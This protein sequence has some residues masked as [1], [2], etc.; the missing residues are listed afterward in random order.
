MTAVADAQ[1]PATIGDYLLRAADFLH[2]LAGWRRAGVAFVAGSVS[3]LSFAPFAIFPL[4]LLSIATL[5]LLLDGSLRTKRPHV[6]AAWI[7]WCFASGQFLFGLYWVGYAFL[8]D[9]AD[10]AWQIPLVEFFLPGGLALFIAAATFAASFYWRPGA[11]RIFVLTLS[12]ACAEWL[13]GHILT[14][15]PWNIPAYA[16]GALPGV[17]QSTAL[18]GSY[19][20]SLLTILFGASLAELANRRNSRAWHLPA[21]VAALFLVLWAGGIMRLA[22]IHPDNVPGVQLRL[23]QPDVAQQDKFKRRY[24]L[25]NW[26]TLIDLS[27]R[28]AAKRP[29]HI[30]WPEA[31]PPVLLARSARGMQDVALLTQGR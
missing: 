15:F 12:Y 27:D 23:V 14:G 3:A 19:G 9:A 22:L 25:R 1:R 4:L 20:L 28:A 30:I 7:G 17:M 8:V 24:R 10:H 21:A 2:G 26:R 11:A 18:F 16:W 6:S 29:T 31:A 5:V 13:R